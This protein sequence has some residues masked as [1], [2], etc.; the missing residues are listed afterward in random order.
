MLYLQNVLRM[1][2]TDDSVLTNSP[3]ENAALCSKILHFPIL[4]L[5]WLILSLNI[6][7]PEFYKT[8]MTCCGQ[9]SS[10]WRKCT[11]TQALH[12]GGKET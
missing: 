6:D 1:I 3:R 2:I 11:L 5:P 12:R 10:I 9:H 7:L 8:V 4:Q